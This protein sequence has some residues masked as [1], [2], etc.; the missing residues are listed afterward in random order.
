[1]HL[2]L[3]VHK[4]NTKIHDHIDIQ[5]GVLHITNTKYPGALKLHSATKIH[6]LVTNFLE[7]TP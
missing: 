2:I 6:Q 3:Q 7:P 5:K 4:Y 1:M